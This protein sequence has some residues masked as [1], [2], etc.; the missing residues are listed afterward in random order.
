MEEIAEGV[1][2]SGV[3]FLWV[4]RGDNSWLKQ[5][6]GTRGCDQ[7]RVLCHSSVGGFLSHCGWNSVLEAM[8]AGVPI[9]S[10]PIFFDQNPNSKQVAEDW[11]VGWRGREG[12]G[13]KDVVSREEIA[14]LVRRFMDCE[15]DEGEELRRRVN[16][17]REIV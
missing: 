12:V 13:D 7:L 10:F 17:V 16:E 2:H 3:R 8:F 11:K 15:S 4:A 9:L 14:G 1:H 5:N 6:C